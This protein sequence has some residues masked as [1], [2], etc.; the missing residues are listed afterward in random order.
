MRIAL[1]DDELSQLQTLHAM[2][3]AS[4]DKLGVVYESI[5]TFSSA[6]EFLPGWQRG[7]YD[8]ILLDIYMGPANGVLLARQIRESDPEVALAFCSSSNEFASES[9]EV[10]AAY[11]LQKPVTAEKLEAMLKRLDLTRLQHS[12]T[13]RLPDGYLCL[14]RRI[15]Y[16]EYSNHSVTFHLSGAEP[17]SVYMKH[18]EAEELL[19]RYGNFG[20]I[21]KGCIVNYAKVRKLTEN[22]FVMEGGAVL[23]ISRRRYKEIS[24][25]YTKYHFER[26]E[27]EVSG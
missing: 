14:L 10:G 20:C 23:P 24:Q 18:A 5:D 4:L 8:V 6:G 2:L 17:H 9:Y 26:M 16:T 25:A 15:L 3:R 21:N 22:A 1:V 19:L 27:E 11:Y 13:L 12:R 7:R